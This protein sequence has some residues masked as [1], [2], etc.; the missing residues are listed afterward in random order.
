MKYILVFVYACIY[1]FGCVCIYLTMYSTLTFLSPTKPNPQLLTNQR[2][3][4]LEDFKTLHYELVF[5]WYMLK[6]DFT[7][8]ATKPSLAL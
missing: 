6:Q 7:T 8:T 5:L 3:R 4:L 2:L 1:V